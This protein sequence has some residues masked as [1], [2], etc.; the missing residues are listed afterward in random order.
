MVG[1][2]EDRWLQVDDIFL[3]DSLAALLSEY[4]RSAEDFQ[5]GLEQS[6][7]DY[8]LMVVKQRYL[9]DAAAIIESISVILDH[10]EISSAASRLRSAAWSQL[11]DSDLEGFLKHKNILSKDWSCFLRSRLE[12]A[13]KNAKWIAILSN[14]ELKETSDPG[15]SA[16]KFL[17]DIV[18]GLPIGPWECASCLYMNG[19]CRDC[20]YG[21][22]HGKCS[23]PESDYGILKDSSETMIQDIRKN[24]A[25]RRWISGAEY[26]KHQNEAQFGSISEPAF[27]ISESDICREYDL[28][29]AFD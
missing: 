26:H 5:Y 18:L 20:E 19:N 3:R 15:H 17:L 16:L 7:S 28:V 13:A 27:S 4:R 24:L 23:L 9:I 8:G 22:A 21:R 14:K 10:Q 2:D 1:A 25:E 29:G 11:D 12:S 6:S